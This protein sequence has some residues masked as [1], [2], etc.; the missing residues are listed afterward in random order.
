MN[1]NTSAWGIRN[2]TPVILLFILLTF[3]GLLSF[4]SMFVQDFPDVNLPRVVVS[5]SLPGAAPELMENEVARK[6]EDT[7]ATVSGVKHLTTTLTDGKADIHIEF[8]LEK[9]I[10]EAVDDV[11]DAVSRIRSDLPADLREPVIRKKEFSSAPLLLY[12]LTSTQLDEE[13]LSWF[14]EDALA[15]TVLAVPGVGGIQRIGGVDREIQIN[16][17][18]DRLLALNISAVEVTRQ[19]RQMQLEAPGGRSVVGGSEQSIRTLGDKRAVHELEIMMLSLNDGRSVRLGDIAK[20]EDSVEERRT[21]AFL[22]GRPVVG[23]QMTRAEGYGEVDVSR[24]VQAALETLQQAHPEVEIREAFNFVEPVVENYQGSLRILYEG[25]LLAVL[26]VF[27]FLRDWRA[28]FITAIALPLSI[29]PTFAL[30]HWMGF[31]LNIVTLLAISLVIGVLVDDAIVEVENIERHLLMGKSA[32]DAALDASAEIGLAVI[33]TTFTLVAVFLPTASMGGSVGRFFVQFGWTA[34]VAVLFSLLVARMLTPMMA[35]YLLRPAKHSQRTPRW[36]ACYQRLA[37]WCLLHRKITLLSA[38]GLFVGGLG[39]AASLPGAF[40][41]ADDKSHTQVTLALPPGSTLAQTQALGEQAW[42]SLAAQK[43][44][45]RVFYAVEGDDVST[46]VMT[47]GLAEREAR[48]GQTRQHIE[49]Q[50]R[51]ALASLPGVRVHVGASASRDSYE[52]VL[53]GGDSSVLQAHARKIEAELRAIPGIGAVSSSASLARPELLIRPDD[54][55][56]ADLGVSTLD[57][58]DTLRIATVGDNAEDLPKLSLGGRQ[59][60]VRVRLSHEARED[61]GT[62]KRLPVPGAQGCVP[63]ENVATLAWS[64]GVSAITRYDRLRN[65]NFEVSLAGHPLSEVEQ[66]VQALP[67]VRQLPDG[68]YQTAAGD[69]EEMAEL[70]VGFGI[71]M[72]TGLLCVY[73]VLVLL[74]KSFLQ[75]LTILVALVLSIPGAF[76]ALFLTGSS[77]S[78]PAMIGLVMLMGIATKNSI[79]LVDYIIIARQENGLER[80]QAILDACGKR[81]RPIVMTTVAMVA[82]MIPIALGWAGDP[83]F[84]APMAFVVIGGLATSTLFSLLIV[85]VAYSCMDDLV[86]WM[87]TKRWVSRRSK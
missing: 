38:L 44:V 42:R 70:G 1:V 35:A 17:L 73:A 3:W 59:L 19:L 66:L 4:K 45:E 72:L 54:V 56:S 77:L 81:A 64:S 12:V 60:P 16:L 14:V 82:G 24:G 13:A 67:S 69:A 41:P 7:I 28:T 76:L 80:R 49:Q 5:A 63:L 27:F 79:L 57:I 15:R 51:R 30:M 2:P 21:A 75:P 37:R 55:R 40:M 18:P 25:M 74:L 85:P 53:A 65:I 11:R 86:Q 23:L 78:L 84:R 20:V 9:P 47:I 50:L 71:S 83:S 46:L 36:I 43:Y 39:L 58:A 22:D 29:I 87:K 32:Q 6:I 62:L 33:A 52:L 61:L 8:R 10:Q 48:A 34:S 31:S 68:V 26:V